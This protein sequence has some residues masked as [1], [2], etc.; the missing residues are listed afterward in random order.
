MIRIT[1]SLRHAVAIAAGTALLAGLSAPAFAAP[2][3]KE[4]RQGSASERTGNGASAEKKICLSN[5]VSGADTVTG[6][7]LQKKKCRTKAEW[8][9]QGVEFGRK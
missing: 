7:I 3:D 9:A 5:T 8:I 1:N 6:S 4:H 2:G